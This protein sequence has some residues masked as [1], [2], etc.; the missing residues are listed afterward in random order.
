MAPR[1]VRR[2][3]ERMTSGEGRTLFFVSHSGSRKRRSLFFR[4]EQVPEFEGK[5]AWFELE[6]DGK[7]GWLVKGQVPPPPGVAR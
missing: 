7:G 2:E 6:R 5:T 1:T 3:L 4:P